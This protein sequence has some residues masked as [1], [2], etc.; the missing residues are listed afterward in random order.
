MYKIFNEDC[1]DTMKKIHKSGNKVDLVLTSP[2]YNISRGV[3]TEEEISKHKSKYKDFK[4]NLPNDEYRKF[5]INVVNHYDMILKENGIVLLNLSYASCVETDSR[6]SDMIKLLYEIV[7]KTNFD[8]ADIITWKKK[9]ALPNNRSSNKLTRIVEYI[10]VLCRKDEYSTFKSNK[11]LTSF[12]EEKNLRFY[13]NI[14]NF[15]EA[16]NNDGN[17]AINKATYSTEL[18]E[19]LLNIYA[20]PNSIIYDSFNG[21]GTTGVAALKLGHSYIG[22]EISKEQCD[23]SIERLN[24]VSE[25][26][27]TVNVG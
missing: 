13:E 3:S 15:V 5:L 27:K 23:F 26:I 20:K 4:D 16:K 21:T 6:C 17:N 7:D 19:K 10:F 1:L 18:C 24:S 14:F 9:S 11:K 22:S 2:P 8:I 12:N 25:E